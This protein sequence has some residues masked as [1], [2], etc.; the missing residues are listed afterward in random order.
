[1]HD[2]FAYWTA[3]NVNR[4]SFFH[5]FILMRESMGTD[6]TVKHGDSSEVPSYRSQPGI[7][8]DIRCCRVDEV[9]FSILVPLKKKCCI[10]FRRSGC[11]MDQ[12]LSQ[13]SII[14]SNYIL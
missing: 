1:M 8:E 3:P 4:R 6:G 11:F 13:F 10:S 2:T 12:K 9:V 7:Q 14:F 5:F